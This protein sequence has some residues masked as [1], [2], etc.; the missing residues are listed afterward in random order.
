MDY[1]LIVDEPV[2]TFSTERKLPSVY[3]Q[4]YKGDKVGFF[5]TKDRRVS[6][7]KFS[8]YRHPSKIPKVMFFN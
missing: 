2:V 7:E 5:Y 1:Q 4:I 8:I 6:T 3:I